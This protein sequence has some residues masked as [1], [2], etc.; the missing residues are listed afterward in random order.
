MNPKEKIY[1]QSLPSGLSFDMI[2]VEGGSFDMGSNDPEALDSEKPVHRVTV[3]TF[4]IG[5]YLVTQEVWEAIMKKNPASYI[6]EKKPVEQVSW[7]DAHQF[8]QKLNAQTNQAYHLP[9]EAE[10][11]F[12]ARGGIH[13][14]GYLYAGSDKLKEVG[15]YDGN[16]N[17]NG[18]LPVGLKMANELGIY[19]MS[20]NVFEWCEDDWH[21]NYEGAPTDGST[22]IEGGRRGSRRVVR[23]GYWFRRCAALPCLLS[24]RRRAG[25]SRQRHWVSVGV[26]SPFGR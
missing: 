22:W 7:E 12:A 26:V 16:S 18:T 10:W 17:L 8:I 3:P 14:E 19:D 13:T 11:E 1:T 15:W 5:K 21:G 9:S 2:R 23:G 4:Y 20:G 25:R 24:Q 6:G